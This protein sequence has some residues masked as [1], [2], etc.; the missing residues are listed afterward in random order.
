MEEFDEGKKG[1]LPFCPLLAQDLGHSVHDPQVG[2]QSVVQALIVYPGLR[3][4]IG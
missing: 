1:S 4:C 2:A 3:L